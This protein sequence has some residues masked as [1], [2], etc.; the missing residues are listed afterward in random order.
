VWI[1]TPWQRISLEVNVKVLDKC[2]ISI[3]VDEID[4]IMLW[5][6]SEEDVNG[7]SECEEYKDTGCEDG[8]SDSDW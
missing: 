8:D 2:C 4:D 1:I 5:Y 3:A 6:S 7:R